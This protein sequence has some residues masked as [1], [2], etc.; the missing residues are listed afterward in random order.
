MIV[1]DDFE[2]TVVVV[3]FTIY[4]LIEAYDELLIEHTSIEDE[5]EFN[6]LH[7]NKV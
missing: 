1:R 3:Y 5:F 7:I 4:E 2:V 6:Q